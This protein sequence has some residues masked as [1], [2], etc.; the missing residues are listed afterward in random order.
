MKSPKSSELRQGLR[1]LRG[2]VR[3]GA[4]LSSATHL[5]LGGPAEWLVEPLSDAE[6][7]TVLRVCRD[8]DVP[9]RVMGGGS[10][11]L[12]AD[13]GVPG[14]V[15]STAALDRIDVDG[16]R[17]S[18]GPG[19][20]L[21]FLLR[22]ARER[23]LAGLEP[24]AGIP[25]MVGGAVAMNAGTREG[26]TF[27][28]IVSLTLAETTGDVSVLSRRECKPRYRDGGLGRRIVLRA[29]FELWAD[30]P[31]EIHARFVRSLSRRNATQPVTEKSIGCVFRNPPGHSAGQL[32]DAAG[33]KRMSSGA[34]TVSDVHAN[35][36]VNRGGG[37]SQDFLTLVDEVR[38]RVLDHAGVELRPE[39]RMWGF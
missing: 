30:S 35:F 14:V 33:C 11:L 12:I 13:R 27:D 39:F 28:R 2:A 32:I 15:I 1:K 29:T 19:V 7:L 23:G 38:A 31:A 36:F 18:A 37:T 34:M 24:L 10:N 26:E 3:Q 6:L 9:V 21:P 17:I 20:S 5:R 4:P 16:N 25:A 22:L 8:L